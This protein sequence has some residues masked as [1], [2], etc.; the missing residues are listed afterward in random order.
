MTSPFAMHLPTRVVAAIA[1]LFAALCVSTVAAA[2]YSNGILEFLGDSESASRATFLGDFEAEAL[3][4]E[5]PIGTGAFE[6]SLF[7]NATSSTKGNVALDCDGFPQDCVVRGSVSLPSLKTLQFWG[8]AY[9]GSG[10]VKP[11]GFDAGRVTRNNTGASLGL[12]LPLGGMTV[13]GFYNYHRDRVFLTGSR[14]EQRDNSY[15]MALYYNAGGF[16]FSAAGL[17]GTDDYSSKKSGLTKKFD[18]SQ[19]AGYL[20]TGYSMMQGGMFVLEPFAAYHYANVRH[21]GFNPATQAYY[22]G[23]KKYNACSATLGSRVNLNLAGLD[24]FTLQGRMAW[25][26]EL[27]SKSESLT[28]FSYGRVPGAFTPASPYYVGNGGGSDVFWAGGGLRLSLMGMFAVSIDYDCLFNKRQTLHEG[29][30]NLLLGF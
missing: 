23:K 1:A 10:H 11:T 16:Y 12:N 8:S 21:D 14:T 5:A 27:R 20:E 29:S 15:G 24:T 17:Y 7:A 18:G 28:T 30:L 6:T 19:S 3:A 25:I 9:S 22:V 26:T 13:S 2:D 4:T